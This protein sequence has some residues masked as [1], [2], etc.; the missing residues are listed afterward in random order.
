MTEGNYKNSRSMP[1]DRNPEPL[2]YKTDGEI[3]WSEMP[4]YIQ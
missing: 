1:S 4:T 2:E 3:Q